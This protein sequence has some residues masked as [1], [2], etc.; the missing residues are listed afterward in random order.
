MQSQS[1]EC[2]QA[3]W[4]CSEI[5]PYKLRREPPPRVGGANVMAGASNLLGVSRLARFT[6]W[7]NVEQLPI[8]DLHVLAEPPQQEVNRPHTS[9]AFLPAESPHVHLL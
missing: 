4:T 5:G 3:L 2:L 1:Y 6:I 8:M 9:L 7:A